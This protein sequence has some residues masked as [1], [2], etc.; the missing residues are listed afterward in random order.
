MY[1]SVVEFVKN[2]VRQVVDKE[3]LFL[4]GSSKVWEYSVENS[5]K[6]GSSLSDMLVTIINK[7]QLA[8]KHTTPTQNKQ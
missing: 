2:V 8:T 6:E 5:V 7:Y 3:P 1:N 4:F